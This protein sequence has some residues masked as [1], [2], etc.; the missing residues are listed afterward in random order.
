MIVAIIPRDDRRDYSSR[1]FY[2]CDLYTHQFSLLYLGAMKV[3]K[4]V[5]GLDL[6]SGKT[7]TLMHW[8]RILLW[9]Q[10]GEQDT[11]VRLLLD[12]FTSTVA[13]T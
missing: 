4:I 12:S 13:F 8:V 11:M 5:I 9:F 6:C 7:Y 1:L 10:Q 3:A 2:V